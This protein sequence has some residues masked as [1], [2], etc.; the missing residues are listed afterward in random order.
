M[1]ETQKALGKILGSMLPEHRH[2]AG[3][4]SALLRAAEKVAARANLDLVKAGMVMSV[5]GDG[6]IAFSFPEEAYVLIP[7][8]PNLAPFVLALPLTPDV[9]KWLTK[10]SGNRGYNE[11]APQEELLPQGAVF[12]PCDFRRASPVVVASIDRDKV[13]WLG[14]ASGQLQLDGDGRPCVLSARYKVEGKE[15]RVS[16]PLYAARPPVGFYLTEKDKEKEMNMPPPGGWPPGPLVTHKS[17]GTSELAATYGPGEPPAPKAPEKY[18]QKAKPASEAAVDMARREIEK[19]TGDLVGQAVEEVYQKLREALPRDRERR[20]VRSTV[21]AG[22][23]REDGKIC[24]TVKFHFEEPDAPVPMVPL[25][26]RGTGWTVGGWSPAWVLLPA[27]QGT[28]AWASDMA[29]ELRRVAT[30][31]SLPEE[32]SLEISLSAWRL[33]PGVVYASKELVKLHADDGAEV[34]WLRPSELSTGGVPPGVQEKLRV[35]RSGGEDWVT[36]GLCGGSKEIF[37]SEQTALSEIAGLAESA[38]K[39]KEGRE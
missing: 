8:R 23:P 25:P 37:C 6:E 16:F 15:V 31:L 22:E 12:Y 38:V 34:V 36:V 4:V 32:G 27:D 18:K 2:P 26:L 28:A 20:L 29:A 24:M 17:D 30:I 35:V 14:Q 10:P 3:A 1:N 5:S 39:E 7:P 11:M 21:E 9:V 13:R 19:I 33:P